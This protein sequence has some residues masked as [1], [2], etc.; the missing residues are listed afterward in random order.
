MLL[1]IPTTKNT[2][3]VDITPW[4]HS[5]A[6]TC[7]IVSGVIAL[8]VM[9]AGWLAGIESIIQIHPTFAPMQFNTALGFLLSGLGI[10]SFYK[11]QKLSPIFGGLALTLGAATLFQYITGV[12]L[13][14][15]ELFIEHYITVE[16]SHPG[17]MA[18]NTALCFTLTGFILVLIHF[19][20]IQ[21]WISATL[22]ITGIFVLV[23]GWMALLGYIFNIHVGY[24]WGQL[25]EMAVH[26]ASGFIIVSIGV[27]ALIWEDS[28]KKHISLLKLIPVLLVIPC[29][30]CTLILW[31][32]TTVYGQRELEDEMTFASK[33]IQDAITSSLNIHNL[34]L[35]RMAERLEWQKTP[36]HEVWAA[37]ARNYIQ[38][39]SGYES[40]LFITN[41]RQIK[42]SVSQNSAAEDSVQTLL[43]NK[44][45]V[46]EINTVNSYAQ[47]YVTLN[48]QINE[49]KHYFMTLVPVDFQDNEFDGFILAVFDTPIL[50]KSGLGN[51]TLLTN[52]KFIIS[53]DNETLF[54]NG[55]SQKISNSQWVQTYN[56]TI[57]SHPFDIRIA[58]ANIQ[59]KERAANVPSIVL[60]SGTLLTLFSFMLSKFGII[61]YINNNRAAKINQI[62]TETNHALELSNK[63]LDEFAHIASHDL[64][65]PLRGLHNHAAFLN[66]DYSEVIDEGGKTKLNRICTL[67]QRMEDLINSLLQYSILGRDE[68]TYLDTDLNMVLEEVLDSLRDRL[69]SNNISVCIQNNFPTIRCDTVRITEV[70]R[71]LITNAMKY[72]N[73][74]NKWIEIGFE[75]TESKKSKSQEYVFF[76]RDNGIGIADKHKDKLFKICKRLHSQEKYGGGTGVGL[77]IVKRIVE[78]HNGK[79]WFESKVDH[80]TV[81]K[82]TV[83]TSDSSKHNEQT[84]PVGSKADVE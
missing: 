78:K 36:Q 31:Q 79:I 75:C 47:K 42:W 21:R 55:N 4:L 35:A 69:D 70:F 18:P 25:T 74:S 67:S 58:P 34:S 27:L 54:S 24:K 56:I 38:Y 80:G 52:Y 49:H 3:K 68:I 51:K 15:D 2:F 64:K 50:L 53:S 17:R 39:F 72:N 6:L 43:N 22:F 13:H 14:I 8:V 73:K 81:F 41:D 40:I 19:Q 30:I 63:E 12:N 37:D 33:V 45:L 29:T 23:M 60:I 84:A 28:I 32:A 82:F 76:V 26:T 5:I 57:N 16:T 83:D 77:S 20:T 66:E 62:L 71:N 59:R 46:R 44:D 48:T 1:E 11:F 7:A 65:E 61:A 10:L 9:V